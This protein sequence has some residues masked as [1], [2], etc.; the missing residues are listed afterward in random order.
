MR[1]QR[2]QTASPCRYKNVYNS[3]VLVLASQSVYYLLDY[4][5]QGNNQCALPLSFL[6]LLGGPIVWP[7]EIDILK[8]NLKHCQQ[9]ISVCFSTI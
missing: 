5:G 1:H 3:E 9:R 7:C 2:N 8:W 6:F 4:W